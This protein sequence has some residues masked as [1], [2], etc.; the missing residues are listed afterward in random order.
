MI[1]A[2]KKQPVV[3]LKSKALREI[4]DEQSRTNQL[5]PNAPFVRLIKEILDERAGHSDLRLRKDAVQALQA[6]S[7]SFIVEMFNESNRL[8]LHSGR[9][10]LSVEDIR[11]WKGIKDI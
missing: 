6:D 2:H 7:E 11:L 3:R 1:T 4:R 8:A 5:I 9:E 10:T